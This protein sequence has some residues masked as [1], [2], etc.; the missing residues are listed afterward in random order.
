MCESSCSDEGLLGELDLDELLAGSHHVLVLDTHDTTTP[1]SV[2]LLVVVELSLELLS[3]LLE[4]DEVLS[5]DLSQGNASGSLEVDKLAKVGLS[6]DEAEGNSLL[7][8][9]GGQVNNKLDWVNVVGDDNE[10]GLVLLDEG[11]HVVETEFEV[12]RLVT[13]LGGS[14]ASLSIALQSVGL[15]LVGLRLVLGEQ[16]K[17]LAGYSS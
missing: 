6:A 1:N 16:F 14:L 10:L 4:V 2:Q 3:E 12:E 17:E 5:A 11:G 13:L 9:E 8:A 7:S 15:V